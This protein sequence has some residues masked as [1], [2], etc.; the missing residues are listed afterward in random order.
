MF[1]RSDSFNAVGVAAF[2]HA[3]QAV[4]TT[5]HAQRISRLVKGASAG[6]TWVTWQALALLPICPLYP[7][8]KLALV[9]HFLE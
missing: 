1:E 7:V 8:H 6:P 9:K 2:V 5:V 4:A 3:R